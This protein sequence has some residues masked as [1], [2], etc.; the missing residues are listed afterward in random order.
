MFKLNRR[1]P[2]IVFAL[3]IGIAFISFIRGKP[4][5][6]VGLERKEM[7]PFVGDIVLGVSTT[8]VVEPQNR[9]EIKPSINGRIEE[10]FVHEGDKVKKGAILAFMSSTDRAALVD[11]ARAKDSETLKYWE[12]VYKQ[13]PV[14]SPIDAEVIVRSVEPGQTVTTSDDIVVLSDRLI[15]NAQLDETDIARVKVGQS[16]FIALDAYPDKKI[17]GVV[18][19]IAYESKLVN[20]VTIYDVDIVPREVPDFFR[21]GMSTNVEIIEDERKNVLLIPVSAVMQEKGKSYVM[22]KRKKK[23]SFEKVYIKT[24]LSDEKNIQVI[25]G[26]S[27]GDLVVTQDQAYSSSSRKKTGSNPFMPQRGGQRK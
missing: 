6:D 14:V 5:G 11:A 25:S 19:H 21:S 2:I 7:F 8:G 24:G 10:I 3:I 26:L 23:R 22:A 16:A 13:S 17:K 15:V 27:V 4:Q 20:N 12:E 1:I 9:L 18:D